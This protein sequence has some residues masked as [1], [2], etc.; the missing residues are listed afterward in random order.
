MMLVLEVSISATGGAMLVQDA[1]T[2]LGTEAGS[3]IGVSTGTGAAACG[4]SGFF[5]AGACGG[6]AAEASA[7]VAG[8]IA[9]MKVLV[10]RFSPPMYIPEEI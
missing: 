8:A 10:L 7:L 6:L 2:G 5:S 9:Q 1:K 3:A 4:G